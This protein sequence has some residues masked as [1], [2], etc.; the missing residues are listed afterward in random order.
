M[1]VKIINAVIG[2]MSRCISKVLDMKE[3]KGQA[4]SSSGKD[5]DISVPRGAWPGNLV[6]MRRRLGFRVLRFGRRFLVPALTHQHRPIVTIQPAAVHGGNRQE[7]YLG[8]NCSP[9]FGAL[10]VGEL[11]AVDWETGGFRQIRAILAEQPRQ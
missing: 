11:I 6:L 4:R 1:P 8:P 2:R 9:C 3:Q 7:A 5:D 10:I